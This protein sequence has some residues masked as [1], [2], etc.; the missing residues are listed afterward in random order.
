MVARDDDFADRR[1]PKDRMNRRAMVKRGLLAGGVGYV[2]P[3]I[4][5]SASPAYA[6]VSTACGCN[7]GLPC[8]TAIPCG[9]NGTC[10]CWVNQAHTGCYCGEGNPCPPLSCNTQADCAAAGFPTYGC[11]DTCCGQTLCWPPCGTI[12]AS[13]TRGPKTG[14][15]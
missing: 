10:F 6:Q 9:P 1:A 11:V 3:M 8:N 13:N 2:A 5:G 14:T 4:L 12:I 7:L 15:K